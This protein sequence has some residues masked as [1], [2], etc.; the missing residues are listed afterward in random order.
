MAEGLRTSLQNDAESGESSHREQLRR[1]TGHGLCVPECHGDATKQAARLRVTVWWLDDLRRLVGEKRAVEAAGAEGWFA[2]ARWGLVEGSLTAFG[3]IVAHGIRYPV[4]LV[5][6]FDFPQIPAW[7]EP[8]EDVRWSGHQYGRGGTL[9]LELRP[10][11]WVPSATGADVLRS[12]YNLLRTENPLGPEGGHSSAPSAHDIGETQSYDWNGHPVLIGAGC[13]DRVKA[14][15]AAELRALRWSP[16]HDIWPIMLHDANDRI[17]A[18]HPPGPDKFSW[19]VEIP[20]HVS[21]QTAPADLAD[22]VKLIQAGQFPPDD[23]EQI[24]AGGDLLA[25]FAG[26][27]E[28]VA[29][30][31]LDGKPHRRQVLV[32]P[33][34]TGLRSARS[35]ALPVASVA[36]V[37]AGSVGS[38]IAETLVRSG[39]RQI[40]LAD[41]D[42]MLPGNIER[43]ILDWRDV[44]LR[45]VYGVRQ[46]L[47][48]IAPPTHVTTIEQNLNWQRSSRMHAGQITELALCDVIVDATGDVATAL[49]LGAVAAANRKPFVSVEVYEGGIGALVASCLPERD[50]PFVEARAAFLAWCDQ[51]EVPP[52][53]SGRR[54]YEAL[55]QDGTPV[56]ADDAAVSAAAAHAARIVLDILDRQPAPIEAAWILFGFRKGWVFDGHGHTIRMSVGEPADA[57]LETDDPE[58]KEFL[59]TLATEGTPAAPPQ[60]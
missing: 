33:D 14:G 5:Y 19:R 58:G 44:G 42:V 21:A 52:P 31:V 15:M 32:I 22:R 30:H 7:V 18:Q 45:K 55:A 56:A 37:G 38:K 46:R 40:V 9:C 54:R 20:V 34:D 12:A 26:G 49:L 35:A 41:G 11:N 50:P 53:P 27:S 39:I 48:Q 57:V 59:R 25:L 16:Q 28:L 3:T 51:Q 13:R 17:A 2:L 1:R 10:D 47:L 6:P 24:E 8:Q 23:R 36:V 60:P 43:H 4:R 29:Y